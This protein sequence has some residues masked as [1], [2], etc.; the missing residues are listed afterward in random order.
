[1]VGYGAIGAR[2]AKVLTGLGCDVSIVSSRR[3]AEFPCY[4]SLTDA[5]KTVQPDYVVV[6]NRTHE[7]YQTI[8]S[9]EKLNYQG[10]VLV[11]KPLFSDGVP[12]VENTFY[13]C[14]VGYNL[15]FHPVIQRLAQALKDEKIIS[16]QAYVGQYLPCWRS[17]SDYRLSYSSDKSQGGGVLR[18]LSHELDLMQWLLGPWEKLCSLMG[19]YSHLEIDSE[20]VTA[21]M[22][23][24]KHCPVVTLQLNYLDRITQREIIINTDSHTFRADLVHGS[25]QIDNEKEVLVVDRDETYR[26]QH[27]A[28][29]NGDRSTLCT[30]AEGMAVVEMI[31][32]IERAFQSEG[33]IRF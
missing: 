16:A 23:S 31:D 7:H 13:D 28:V 5:L 22:M 25:L 4:I 11:E 15:R 19:Q 12:P 29:L 30:F 18:D 9:L 26:S 8:L 20:D 33:W 3:T 14:F 1:M 6:A 32:A 24:T 27:Q 10:M 2:H 21:I 17:G